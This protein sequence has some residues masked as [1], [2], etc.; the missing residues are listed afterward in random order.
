MFG[1]FNFKKPKIDVFDEKT[2]LMIIYK[3]FTMP[4]SID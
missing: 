3:Y 1:F 2:S 4:N